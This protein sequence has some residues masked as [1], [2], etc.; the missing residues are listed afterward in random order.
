M[1]RIVDVF[2]KKVHRKTPGM[3]ACTLLKRDYVDF[4]RG[5]IFANFSFINVLYILLFSW[6]VLQPVA[7]ESRNSYPDFSIFQIALFGYKT[8][9]SRLFDIL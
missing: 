8:L 3:K 4:L 6:F 5:F 9:N 1:V 7:C 2:F